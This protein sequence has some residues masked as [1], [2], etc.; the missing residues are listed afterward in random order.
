[1]Y[2]LDVVRIDKPEYSN[3][4][5]LNGPEQW[6]CSMTNADKLAERIYKLTEI[7]LPLF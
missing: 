3:G 4:F 7:G 5:M 1:V 2:G 6:K